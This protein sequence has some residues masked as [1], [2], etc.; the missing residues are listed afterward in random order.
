MDYLLPSIEDVP[1]SPLSESQNHLL[2]NEQHANNVTEHL[3][4][5]SRYPLTIGL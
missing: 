2:G 5:D 4:N 3:E 1:A